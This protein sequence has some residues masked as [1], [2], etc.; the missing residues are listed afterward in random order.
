MPPKIRGEIFFG[1]LLCKIGTFSGKNHVKF[2][3]FVNFSGKYYLKNS[4]ILLIFLGK[5]HVKFGHFVNFSYIFFS[6]TNVVP[7]K[8]D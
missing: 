3:N 8:V 2:G 1:Q 7:P 5:N 4:G 6:G